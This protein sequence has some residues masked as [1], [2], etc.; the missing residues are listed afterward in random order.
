MFDDP[1]YNEG[2]SQTQLKIVEMMT[3]VLCCSSLTAQTHGAIQRRCN[4]MDP[5]PKSLWVTSPPLSVKM[6]AQMDALLP[7]S[8]S[9]GNTVQ[10][11]VNV[12]MVE[13]LLYLRIVS[14][15]TVDAPSSQCIVLFRSGSASDSVYTWR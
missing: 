4:H 10:C 3:E 15:M 2:D 8:W 14:I 13:S 7:R 5:H 11:N 1:G 9:E 6:G 12:F